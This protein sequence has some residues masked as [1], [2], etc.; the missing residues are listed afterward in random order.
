M[1]FLLTL[2][3]GKRM[4]KNFKDSGSNLYTGTEGTGSSGNLQPYQ[5]IG[6]MWIRKS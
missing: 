4:E 2:G 3:A 5:V 6:Y 1:Y